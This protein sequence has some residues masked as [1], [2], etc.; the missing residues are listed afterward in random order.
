MDK[1]CTHSYSLYEWC[2]CEKTLVAIHDRDVH[3]H[4]LVQFTSQGN[5]IA[6]GRK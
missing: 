2:I 6:K 1:W 3:S 5:V 4:L